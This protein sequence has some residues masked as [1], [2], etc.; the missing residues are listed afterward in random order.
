MIKALMGKARVNRMRSL[1]SLVAPHAGYIYSGSVAAHAYRALSEWLLLSSV[2]ENPVFAVV[3]PNHTGYG[4]A[5]SLSPD[6]WETPL[7]RVRNSTEVTSHLAMYSDAFSVEREAHA[8]E[9]SLEVQLPFLQ[10]VVKDPE[11]VFICMGDQSHESGRLVAEALHVASEELG[12]GIFVIAS[13]DFNHYESAEAAERKDMPA[14]RRIEMLD[15]PGFEAAIDKYNDTACG[16]GPVSV[17]ALYAGMKGPAKGVLLKYSNSGAV[18]N[19]FSSVVAYA[20]IAFV[21]QM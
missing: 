5:L 9:H 2:H 8:S 19:D 21:K 17:A 20:S 11:C 12:K 15:V 1:A 14:I 7:G 13:S 10:S 18:N 4:A 3:G 6:D 16:H